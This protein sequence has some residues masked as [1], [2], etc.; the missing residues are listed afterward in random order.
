M[1]HYRNG[2]ISAV[3]MAAL[4]IGLMAL[5]IQPSVGRVKAQDTAAFDEATLACLDQMRSVG[6]DM[7]LMGMTPETIISFCG[8][9][10]D[11]EAA[12]TTFSDTDL[13]MLHNVI[14]EAVINPDMSMECS[15]ILQGIGTPADGTPD[16]Q[17][18]AG[19]DMMGTQYM[20]PEDMANMT[21][22]MSPISREG[23]E[24]ATAAQ[25]GTDLEYY[26]E[27]GVKVFE[28]NAYPVIWNI[29]PNVSTVAWTYNGIMPGP[30]IRVTEG[31]RVRII[32]NNGLPEPSTVHWHGVIVPQNMDGVPH[33]SQA[34]VEP[35]QSFTY[36]FTIQQPAGTFWYHSHYHDDF[37][38]GLGLHGAFII[39]PLVPEENP[40]AV[41]VTLMLNEHRIL[42]GNTFASMPM[43]GMDP[44]YFTINGKS[45]PS[46]QP[47][48]AR[49]GERVRVRFIV[50]GQFIHPMHLHG[51]PFEVVEIDGYPVPP[52]NRQLMDTVSIAPGQRFVIEF[53]PTQP[54]P[55][56]LHC[57]IPHHVT[58]NFAVGHGGLT[59]A[60]VVQ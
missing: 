37:Q 30:T 20:S 42:G 14:M 29:L 11:A 24:P 59:L 39:E 43:G 32:F 4:I 46:T 41:D 50:V 5:L 31:D 45:Y 15:S 57:H 19:L 44:N 36:E 34:P 8:C 26:M 7:E 47:I 60:V 56:M 55:W 33:L 13:M 10:R 23:V 48:F 6:V 38:I 3:I 53:T 51:V 2:R 21:A 1:N 18:L 17:G 54:G 22:H 35:G 49:V 58:N 27:D 12:G 28:L 40:P 9:V 16:T 25:G 52:E